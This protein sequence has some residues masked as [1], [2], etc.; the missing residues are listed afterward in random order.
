MLI[1]VALWGCISQGSNAGRIDFLNTSASAL[2]GQSLECFLHSSKSG[3]PI[4]R[5]CVGR[6]LWLRMDV[7]FFFL[8]PFP[9]YCEEYTI[10]RCWAFRRVSDTYHA[11][12]GLPLS[13]PLTIS[14]FNVGL[15]VISCFSLGVHVALGQLPLPLGGRGNIDTFGAWRPLQVKII[16]LG[17]DI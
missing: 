14:V 1:I 6:I 9:V 17:Q 8:T 16:V 13:C 5:Q 3:T 15:L 10:T 11:L 2:I 7:F 12:Y 4:S